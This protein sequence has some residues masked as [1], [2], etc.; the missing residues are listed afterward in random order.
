MEGETGLCWPKIEK[1]EGI[2]DLFLGPA[3]RKMEKTARLESEM[4]SEEKPTRSEQLQIAIFEAHL[5]EKFA[6]M[7]QE[8]IVVN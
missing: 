8:L 7:E 2:L 6:Y 3:E 1:I 4:M 5:W